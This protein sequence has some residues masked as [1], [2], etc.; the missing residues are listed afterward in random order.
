MREINLRAVDLNL[1]TIFEAVFEE[2]SQ[3]K[4]SERLGMTQPAISHAMEIGRAHV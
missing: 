2:C 4:A 3:I 1:L